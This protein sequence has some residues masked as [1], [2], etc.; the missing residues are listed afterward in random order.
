MNIPKENNPAMARTIKDGLVKDPVQFS[1]GK[2]ILMLSV[3]A[4]IPFL[5]LYHYHTTVIEKEPHLWRTGKQH[6]H[7]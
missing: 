3:A 7:R 1:I 2:K 6:D 5:I 4:M